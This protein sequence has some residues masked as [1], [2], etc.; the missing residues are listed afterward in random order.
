MLMSWYRLRII[1]MQ[2]NQISWHKARRCLIET[3]CVQL[4]EWLPTHIN[5]NINV[6]TKHFY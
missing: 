5:G 6:G 4:N 2:I 3:N 1:R